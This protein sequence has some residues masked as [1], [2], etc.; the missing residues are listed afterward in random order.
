MLVSVCV[1]GRYGSYQGRTGTLRS[2]PLRLVSWRD[3]DKGVV[4]HS[5]LESRETDGETIVAR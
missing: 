2:A 5:N 3:V 1:L 4:G